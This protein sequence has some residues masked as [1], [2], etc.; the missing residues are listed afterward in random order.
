MQWDHGPS[1][2]SRRATKLPTEP[3]ATERWISWMNLRAPSGSAPNC[4]MLP[5]SSGDPPPQPSITEDLKRYTQ[6]QWTSACWHSAHF[7]VQY[8]SE[9]T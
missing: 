8:L 5:M 1:D 9:P 4:H 6:V 7:T 3:Q 2:A